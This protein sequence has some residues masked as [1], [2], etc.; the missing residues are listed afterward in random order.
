MAILE[1]PMLLAMLMLQTTPPPRGTPD[2]RCGMSRDPE[3]LDCCLHLAIWSGQ[4]PTPA[5]HFPSAQTQTAD[6][7]TMKDVTKR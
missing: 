4:A 6:E 5:T 2:H 3:A 7:R 1:V